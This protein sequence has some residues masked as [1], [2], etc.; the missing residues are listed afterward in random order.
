MTLSKNEKITVYLPTNLKQQFEECINDLNEDEVERVLFDAVRNL[1]TL[2]KTYNLE[3][4]DSISYS[5]YRIAVDDFFNDWFKLTVEYH[6][7][8]TDKIHQ[9]DKKELHTLIAKH[10]IETTPT[11]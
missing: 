7:K 11:E 6:E 10:I 4:S 1:D 5:S 8:Y 3:E 9:M 2:T